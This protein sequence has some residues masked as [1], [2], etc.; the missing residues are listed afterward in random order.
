MSKV[1]EDGIRKGFV[2]AADDIG[3]NLTLLYKMSGDSPFFQGEQG[4]QRLMGMNNAIAGATALSSTSDMITLQAAKKVVD[5]ARVK[6]TFDKLGIGTATNTYVDY[7]RFMERGCDPKLFKEQMQIMESLEKS[8]VAGLIGRIKNSY[9]LNY[10]G[11]TQLWQ[12]RQNL[13]SAEAKGINYEAETEQEIKKLMRNPDFKSDSANIA[14]MTGAVQKISV[15]IG[16]LNLKKWNEYYDA[17]LTELRRRLTDNQPFVPGDGKN[18]KSGISD[19]TAGIA[20]NPDVS[21]VIEPRLALKYEN[22]KNRELTNEEKRYYQSLKPH[23]E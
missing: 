23:W 20:E 7:F 3:S 12:L 21:S 6:G 9:G 22:I 14:D 8:N 2:H 19:I 16:E 11:A 17:A 13:K 10:Q 4:V 15:K 1:M 5:E 18:W